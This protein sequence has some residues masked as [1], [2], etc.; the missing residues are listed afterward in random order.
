MTRA[1]D[2]GGHFQFFRHPSEKLSHHINIKT[3]FKTETRD[4]QK[5]QRE[6][7]VYKA[8]T[9]AEKIVQIDI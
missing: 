3:V 2:I 6:R 4:S 8:Q 1:V 5:Q 9:G 7:S